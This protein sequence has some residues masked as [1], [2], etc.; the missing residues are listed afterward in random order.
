MPILDL[1]LEKNPIRLQLQRW[2]LS[3]SVFPVTV[4]AQ[5]RSSERAAEMAKI[6]Q[7]GLPEAATRGDNKHG[8]DLLSKFTAAQH[9][10]PEFMTDMR[11]LTSCVSMVFAGSET[12]AISLSSI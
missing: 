6:K 9:E 7:Y 5:S 12:T 1:L 4:F 10:H 11:V 2:G 8:I 3:K